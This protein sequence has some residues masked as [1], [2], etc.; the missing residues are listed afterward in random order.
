MKRHVL[1]TILV[2]GLAAGSALGAAGNAAG[3]YRFAPG[4]VIDVSVT[5]QHVFDRTITVQPDGRI[6]FPVVG[7]LQAAGVTVAQLTEQLRAG[8][9]RDLVA[10]RVTV[11]LKELNKQAVP[12]VSVLGAVRNPGVFEIKDG[13]TVAEALASAGGPSPI[14][15]LRR[16]TVTRS[17]QAV[18]TVDLARSATSGR[19]ERN[20]TLQ[21]GDLIVVPQGPPPTVLVLGEVLRPGSYEIQG[22]ARVLDAISLAGGPTPKA[23]MNRVTLGRS[24]QGEGALGVG[25][26]ALGV[27]T[28][29]RQPTTNN[30]PTP[31]AQRLTPKAQGPT[32]NAP[33]LLNLQPL[34]EQGNAA[35]TD[36]NQVLQPGDTIVVAESEQHVYVLGRVAKPDVYPIKPNDRVLDALAKAGGASAEGDLGRAVLVRRDEKG[37]PVAK[38]LDLKKLIAHGSMAPNEALLPGDVL[39][40]P[41]KKTHRSTADLLNLVWPI[42]GLLNAIR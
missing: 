29:D 16:V 10:P 19:M 23:D 17:N 32:P 25:R 37:Q 20:V 11:S 21:P 38:P 15:D 24:G 35:D 34:L 4:D 9:D 39:F 27:G 1:S 2:L 33:L 6:S 8:L 40:V 30:V 28:D 26:W 31:N 41:D 7:Q 36:A 5:P 12:R 13:T 14:A 42:T 18:F 22:E 3:E